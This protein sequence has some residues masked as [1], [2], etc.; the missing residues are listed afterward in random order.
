FR[1]RGTR[2]LR[3]SL[4][5][6]LNCSA[7]LSLFAPKF[8]SNQLDSAGNASQG[9][10]RSPDRESPRVPALDPD[11]PVVLRPFWRFSCAGFWFFS[12]AQSDPRR[13]ATSYYG[14]L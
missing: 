5:V 14:C 12:G 13:A 2:G 3:S 10:A 8:C 4:G 1:L 11:G 7:L 6:L 9:Q